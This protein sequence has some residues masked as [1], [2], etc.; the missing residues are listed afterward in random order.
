MDK[1]LRTYTSKK[2][3]L[4]QAIMGDLWL[5]THNAANSYLPFIMAALDGNIKQ[6]ETFRGEVTQLRP[7][8]IDQ[9]GNRSKIE[10]ARPG[11]TA[12][13]EIYGALTKYDG[14]CSYGMET[15]GEWIKQAD[16]DS[17]INEIVLIVDSPGGQASGTEEFSNLIASAQKP[18]VAW[19]NGQACSAA[20]FAIAPCDHIMLSS[21]S[22]MMGSIGTQFSV[23]DFTEALKARGYK[24]HDI[25]ATKSTDKNQEYFDILKGD[26]ESMI[27]NYLDPLNEVFITTIEKYRNVGQEATTGKT[28]FGQAAIDAGL[29]DSI[30]TLDDA[31]AKAKE[32]SINSQNETEMSFFKNIFAKKSEEAKA[33]GKEL[34]PEQLE[35]AA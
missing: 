8:A 23:M 19:V 21:R 32:L 1:D 22:S 35:Q 28:Y 20:N 24:R 7:L 26:Y 9:E 12:L 18:T 4:L 5:I 16:R 30:G 13:I 33:E 34:T 29:A 11:S 2:S 6:M 14:W 3:Q 10:E 31:I 17:N 27:K 15:I 25:R